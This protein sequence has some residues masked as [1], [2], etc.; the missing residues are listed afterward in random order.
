MEILQTI[1]AKTV[2]LS[3]PWQDVAIDQ[4][5]IRGGQVYQHVFD[6]PADTNARFWKDVRQLYFAFQQQDLNKIR[7]FY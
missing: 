3:W 5:L 4:G 7:L 1:A 6:N 2:Y